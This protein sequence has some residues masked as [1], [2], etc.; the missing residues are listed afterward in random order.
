RGSYFMLQFSI[1]PCCLRCSRWTRND[2]EKDSPFKEE[3]ERN[4]KRMLTG[5]L[6]TI[7]AALLLVQLPA[8][9]AQNAEPFKFFRDYVGLKE[10]QI[11]AI[12]NG[13]AIAKVIESRTPDE[14]FVFG[15]A[16]VQSTPEKY[17]KLASD[18]D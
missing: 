9:N 10:D 8:S 5:F 4:A 2:S 13:K 6:K 3:F 11:A 17:L 16:Y 18:M 12:R 14:V 15:S 7:L 1:S